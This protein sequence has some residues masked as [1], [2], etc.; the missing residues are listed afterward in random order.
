M[1]RNRIKRRIRE[2]LRR[3]RTEIPTGWDIVIHPR[4]QWRRRRSR[5]WRRNWCACCAPSR[6]PDGTPGRKHEPR[7]ARAALCRARLP[8]FFFGADAE[9]LQVLSFLL[10]LCRRG[11]ANP[12]RAA[13][14]VA[15]AAARLALP[16][17]HA[18][19]RGSRARCRRFSR[20]K[21]RTGFSLWGSGSPMQSETRQAEACPTK[22]VRS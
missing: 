20:T 4:A 16:S 2:I 13:R 9:R 8:G 1:V 6:T 5:R 19:R 7:G 12:R 11:S 15:R 3:N 18:G 10:A 14:F 22:E 17:V 21:S